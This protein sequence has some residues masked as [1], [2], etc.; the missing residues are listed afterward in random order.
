[1]LCSG[2][3]K[4]V[5]IHREIEC[6]SEDNHSDGDTTL[7]RELKLLNKHE[8]MKSKSIACKIK[9]KHEKCKHGVPKKSER[10]KNLLKM[11]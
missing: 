3:K 11:R 10:N 9:E 2:P 8:N 6:D 1:M 5:L 7:M 4:I